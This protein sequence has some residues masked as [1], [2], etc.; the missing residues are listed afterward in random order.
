MSR[1]RAIRNDASYLVSAGLL[2]VAAVTA[3]T[4]LVADR[5]DLNEFVYH[6]Y[7]GYALAVLALAIVVTLFYAWAAEV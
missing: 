6:K 3:A 4:G 5:W 2:V 1:M 7:A